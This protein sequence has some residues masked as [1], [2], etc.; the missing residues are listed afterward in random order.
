[1]GQQKEN[2]KIACFG[3]FMPFML[4]DRCK[5]A[6]WVIFKSALVAGL[7]FSDDCIA[8]RP[9]HMGDDF[10]DNVS[11]GQHAEWNSF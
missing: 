2:L 6:T 8:L 3:P 11:M 5:L 4:V 10:V 1:M 9:D 7:G